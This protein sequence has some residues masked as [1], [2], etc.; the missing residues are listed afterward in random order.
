MTLFR[1]GEGGEAFQIERQI[2]SIKILIRV[3]ATSEQTVDLFYFID[4]L[5]QYDKEL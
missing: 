3:S 4:I 2:K 5:L 1:C